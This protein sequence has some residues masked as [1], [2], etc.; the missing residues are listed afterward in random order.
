MVNDNVSGR[1]NRVLIQGLEE[2]YFLYLK[3]FP[4]S[5]DGKA[6]HEPFH[7]CFLN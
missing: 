4:S 3:L 6:V 7:K 5:H 1:H 2:T